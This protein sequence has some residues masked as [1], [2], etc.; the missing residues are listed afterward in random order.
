MCSR[1]FLDADGNIIAYTFRVPL[2]DRIKRRFNIAPTQEAPVIRAGAGSARELAMLRWGLVPYWAKDL[3]VGTK[4]INAR[5]EGVEAKPAFRAAV[6]ERRCVVPATGFFEWQGAA[7]HKQPFAVTLPGQELFGFAALWER[8]KAPG[9]EAIETFAIVTTEA[10]EAITRIHDRMPVILPMDAIDT[11]LTAPPDAARA[12]LK[13]YEGAVQ[14][15]AVGKHVSNVNNE[16]P[17]CL[18]DAEPAWDE[19]PRQQSL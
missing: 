18:N 14:L 6:R 8:W 2:T 13:P 19:P 16:G 10:N 15:R 3:K 11:W 17:E 1:Y 12:L 9:G 5:S 4:M 7:G